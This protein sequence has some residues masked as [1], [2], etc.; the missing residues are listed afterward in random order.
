MYDPLVGEQTAA[1]DQIRP[2]VAHAGVQRRLEINVQEEQ[3]DREVDTGQCL[4]EPVG[5][6]SSR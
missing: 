1:V 2:Q 4:V 3:R 6:R 5:T